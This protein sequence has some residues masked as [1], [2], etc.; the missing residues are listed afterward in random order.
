MKVMSVF[1]LNA[2]SLVVGFRPHVLGPPPVPI[3]RLKVAS[4]KPEIIETASPSS[5][6]SSSLMVY[7]VPEQV[8]SLNRFVVDVAK[9]LLVLYY[10]DNTIARFYALETI[11][12][13]P[14]FSYTSVLH[15]YETTGAFRKKEFIKLHFE[16]S[17]NE[18]HHLLVMEALGGDEKFQD[19]FL[20][21]HIAFF[22]YWLVVILYIVSPATAYHLN[23][24]VEEHAYETYTDYIE[25]N[26]DVL[27][28]KPAPA[29]AVQ[30]YE[31]DIL[32]NHPDESSA[33]GNI[34]VS[35]SSSSSSSSSEGSNHE[36]IIPIVER[37]Q[38]IET[39][40][41]TFVNI[42]ADEAVHARTMKQLQQHVSL[43]NR[44][45]RGK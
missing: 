26:Q 34:I 12:R 32:F 41:D 42:R 45:D 23:Q 21:Q 24:C 1:L 35:S 28:S 14:Y 4:N 13:V 27:K 22:Y 5:S 37:P 39:L 36:K 11:A 7:V 3:M 17:W 19:R 44:G 8:K 30:Y 18:L 29:V 31:Q 20:A 33:Y 25:K 2:L 43:L 38:K 15:L 16:E 40:Y 9:D 6:S 10:G